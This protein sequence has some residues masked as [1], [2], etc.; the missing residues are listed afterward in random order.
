MPNLQYVQPDDEFYRVK[1]RKTEIN[2]D[3]GE[4]FVSEY[5]I[6][7]H[8][9]LGR[10]KG[11]VTRHRKDAQRWNDVNDVEIIQFER[12]SKWEVIEVV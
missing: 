4:T 10:L 3:D 5:Y 9:H 2:K 11:E 6:G 1:V 7:P 8:T 12:M